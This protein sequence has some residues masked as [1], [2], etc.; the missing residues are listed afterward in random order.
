MNNP[1]PF[2]PM[3]CTIS[4]VERDTGVAKE[5]LRVWERRYAFP[6]P[7]RDPFGE[8][9][10]PVEQVHKL[11]LVK[12]LIDLGFRP[13]KVIGY[14]AQELQALAE[15][16]TSGNRPRLPDATELT[17]YLDLCRSHD[18]DGL[19]RKLS[20]ALLVMGLRNFVIDLMAPLTGAIGD[21][22][23]CGDLGVW[24]EH[25]LTETLQ[26]VL[27]SAIFSMP[28]TNPLGGAPRPRILLT[29]TPQ[30]RHGLGLLMSEALMVAEGAG[31]YSLGPQTPLPD[32][33]EAARALQVDVVTLSF[34][35]SMNTR[36][37][38]DALKELRAR[39][40]EPVAL[41]A[42]GGNAAL[43]RRAPAY[44][45]VLTLPDVAAAL[46]DWRH[47]QRRHAAA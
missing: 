4:D 21:A 16:T 43:R 20:Q 39:L 15:K 38:L 1:M 11:R 12:R 23:A 18:S 26:M 9:L 34:S 37:V 7:E 22:W 24:Q 5:T 8:R 6:R 31:C 33:V 32:I 3:P 10:Y 40:P 28:P 27:R 17:P 47:E 30:E 19:R 2:S 44:V 14:T 36:H 29:T 35:T 46:A 13:G 25:L 42:G 41:W 45:Q